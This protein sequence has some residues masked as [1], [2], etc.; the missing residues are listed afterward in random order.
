MVARL[1]DASMQYDDLFAAVSATSARRTLRPRVF[2]QPGN[3]VAVLQHVLLFL[4]DFR[5]VQMV[6]ID[7][8]TMHE[9][10]TKCCAWRL[11]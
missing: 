4:L 7:L 8:K 6:N 10:K 1:G 9:L 5:I 2:S 11:D 3:D